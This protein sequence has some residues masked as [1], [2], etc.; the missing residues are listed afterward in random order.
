M[1][2]RDNDFILESALE[3]DETDSF[4]EAESVSVGA[5]SLA[6]DDSAFGSFP[7][8][9]KRRGSA[10]RQLQPFPTIQQVQ[11]MMGDQ[12]KNRNYVNKVQQDRKTD[13]SYI[14]HI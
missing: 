7:Q 13:H 8:L 6:S 11:Q 4:Y 5:S 14:R 1:D 10:C 3:N 9:G 12:N 2:N